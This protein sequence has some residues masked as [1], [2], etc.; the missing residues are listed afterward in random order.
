MIRQE[1]RELT[2]IAND[3][4]ESVIKATEQRGKWVIDLVIPDYATIRLKSQ[5]E[6]SRRFGSLEAVLKVANSICNNKFE[7]K[8]GDKH[9]SKAR[10]ILS[11]N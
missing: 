2:A 11:V 8:L 3:H 10:N 1:E 4:P 9:D 7:I 5:R 6:Q